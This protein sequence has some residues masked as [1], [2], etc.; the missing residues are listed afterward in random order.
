MSE[1]NLKFTLFADLHYKNGY[2]A[3]RV[4]DVEAIVDAARE[5]GAD[6]ILHCGD[7]CNDYK[8]SP[9]LTRTLLQNPYGLPVAGVYGNHELETAGNDMPLVTPLLT[10]RRG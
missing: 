2:Y 4:A 1:I 3:A 9:E 8:G 6:L 5:A 7:L 10:N